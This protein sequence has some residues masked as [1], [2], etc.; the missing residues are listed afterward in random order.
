MIA[1]T[2]HIAIDPA[3]IEVA[4]VLAAGPGGQNVNKVSSA[5]QL[6]FDIRHSPSLPGYVRAK[7]ERLAGSRLTKDGVI[8]IQAMRHR[9]QE[10]NRADA[11][12]R[13]VELLREASGRQAFRVKTKPSKAA[14][15][16][17]VDAKT[18]RGSVKKLR[19]GKIG[20]D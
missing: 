14:K 11:V 9:T 18:K 20:T 5:V 1:I 3:E 10:L 7:A 16:R 8:V 6:R 4:F 13:L 2:D 17:R 15:R 12:E 19:S